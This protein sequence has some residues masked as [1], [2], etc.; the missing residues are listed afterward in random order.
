M[1]SIHSSQ[2]IKEGTKTVVNVGQ[3]RHREVKRFGILLFLL[4]WLLQAHSGGLEENNNGWSFLLMAMME[5]MRVGG[6]L[7][8]CVVGISLKQDVSLSCGYSCHTAK[9]ML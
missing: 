1:F 7:E 4:L 3:E 5:T 9:G 8:E 2:K 6:G